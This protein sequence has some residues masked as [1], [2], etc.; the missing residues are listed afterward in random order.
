MYSQEAGSNSLAATLASSS[1]SVVR[2]LISPIRSR[3]RA[4]DTPFILA[5][6]FLLLP[7]TYL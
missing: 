6:S 3:F 4:C 2:S 7:E 1:R 5:L